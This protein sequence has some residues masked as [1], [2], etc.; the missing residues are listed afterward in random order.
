MDILLFPGFKM[1]AKRYRNFIHYIRE[2]L[3]TNVHLISKVSDCIEF[4]GKIYILAHS[5]GIL[6][7]II[8]CET[9][10]LIPTMIISMDGTYLDSEIIHSIIESKPPEVKEVYELYLDTK[11]AQGLY[12]IPIYLF[13]NKRNRNV[14]YIEQDESNYTH[15][16]YYDLENG[17]HPY[18]NKYIRNKI[19]DVI[20]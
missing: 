1:P 5:I 6:N 15:V 10:N 19:V 13:R 20:I 7:A 16:Y 9:N 8:Y 2:K 12:S 3:D 17:H 18:D 11:Y 4:K 14:Q